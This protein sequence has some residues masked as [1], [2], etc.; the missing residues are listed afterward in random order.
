MIDALMGIEPALVLSFELLPRI[1]LGDT[2]EPPTVG[3]V[4]PPYVPWLRWFA[5]FFH[6]STVVYLGLRR[7]YDRLND[8]GPPYYVRSVAESRPQNG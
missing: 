1:G 7:M 6:R 3:T 2:L 5:F 8:K 4:E